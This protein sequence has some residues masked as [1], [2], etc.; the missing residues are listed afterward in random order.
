MT[1]AGVVSLP[2]MMTGQILAGAAPGDAARYQMLV[3]FMITACVGLATFG[4]VMLAW[5]RL[6]SSRHEL[7]L[8]RLR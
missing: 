3:M 5:L 4:V 1:T 7:R 2:G 6:F 8:D